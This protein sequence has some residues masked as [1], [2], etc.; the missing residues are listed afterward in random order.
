MPLKNKE[1]ASSIVPRTA[2]VMGQ[3]MH[4]PALSLP[5]YSRM[6]AHKIQ[7]PALYQSTRPKPYTTLSGNLRDL[8]LRFPLLEVGQW[9]IQQQIPRRGETLADNN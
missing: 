9:A 4:R 3:V 5:D 2:Q 8:S 7:R 1:R 6:A